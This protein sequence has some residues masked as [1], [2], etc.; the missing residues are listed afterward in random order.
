MY[1]MPTIS[2]RV[3]EEERRRLAKYVPLSETVRE[4]SEMYIK[5]RK[6]RGV[7]RELVRFQKE[8]PVHVDAEEIVRIIREG[9]NH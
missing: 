4:A 6:K 1:Y 3:S 2:V 7:I 8:H 5:E 9:R